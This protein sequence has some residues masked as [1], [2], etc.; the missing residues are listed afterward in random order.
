MKD[1]AACAF[2]CVRARTHTA[3]ARRDARARDRSVP[4]FADD[5]GIALRPQRRKNRQRL[6]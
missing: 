1:R 4:Y 3:L 6:D 5:S 2:V